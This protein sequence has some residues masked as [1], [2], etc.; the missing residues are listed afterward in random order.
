MTKLDARRLWFRRGCRH[1]ISIP[2]VQLTGQLSSS[3]DEEND[4]ALAFGQQ[5]RDVT[6]ASGTSSNHPSS[7]LT[8]SWVISY[9][10]KALVRAVLKSFKCS[11]AQSRVLVLISDGCS[12]NIRSPRLRRIEEI[13]VRHLMLISVSSRLQTVSIIRFMNIYECRGRKVNGG[14]RI[15]SSFVANSL[16]DS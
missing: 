1:L 2:V 7:R 12:Q 8:A 10:L 3:A 13:V 16:A 14:F 9:R 5:S 11:F 15:P 4:T 6:A